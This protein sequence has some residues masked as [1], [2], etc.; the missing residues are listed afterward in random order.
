MSDPYRPL[1]VDAE[2]AIAAEKDYGIK[3]ISDAARL[4]FRD[5]PEMRA[6]IMLH[7]SDAVHER[8]IAEARAMAKVQRLA[9]DMSKEQIHGAVRSGRMTI[10]EAMEILIAKLEPLG[11]R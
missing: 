1:V 4:L 5:N 11:R 7:P 8:A 6:R 9:G 3:T 2:A 10:V